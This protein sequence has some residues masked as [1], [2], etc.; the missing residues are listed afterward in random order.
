MDENDDQQSKAGEQHQPRI[1]R[2]ENFETLYANTC[3]IEATVWDLKLLFGEL[4]SDEQGG[5]IEQ[6]TGMTLPWTLVKILAFHLAI[7]VIAFEEENGPIRLSAPML[8]LISRLTAKAKADPRIMA[9]LTALV[10]KSN[11]EL[12]TVETPGTAKPTEDAT[13]KPEPPEKSKPV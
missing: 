3:M 13:G 10:A 2:S 6:H 5:V 4:M 9:I 1:K 11:P 7:N 8:P 12:F